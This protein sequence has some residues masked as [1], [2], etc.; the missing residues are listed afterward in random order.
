[1]DDRQFDNW[2]RALAGPGSRRCL[3][4]D[5]LGIGTLIALVRRSQI[6]AAAQYGTAGPG[7][8]CRDSA[9]C[10][11]ADAPLV[12]ADNGFAYDGPLNCC[13]FEGSRCGF[14]AACCGAA[15]CVDGTCTN[16]STDLG[17]GEPCR[18]DSQCGNEFPELGILYCADNGFYDDG[19]LHCCRYE[20]G[21]CGGPLSDFDAAC[22]GDLL[23]VGGA[24]RRVTVYIGPGEPCQASGQCQATDTPLHCDY[25]ASTDDFRCCS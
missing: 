15:V 17:P 12:C 16:G 10:V 6:G 23:C 19:P 9:R 21:I 5:L 22:C 25:V 8:P 13:T 1:M 3:L 11:A 2:V 7:D 20:G 24:C 4:R 14:D 18:A